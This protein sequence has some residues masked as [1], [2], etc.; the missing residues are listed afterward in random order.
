[1]NQIVRIEYLEIEEKKKYEKLI[2]KVVIQCFRRREF[3]RY[4]FIHWYYFNKS[5]K[6]SKD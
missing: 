4:K 3:I 6:H 5:G 2:Q 1:M